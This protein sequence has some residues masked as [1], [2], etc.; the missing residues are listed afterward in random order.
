MTA[1]LYISKT[2]VQPHWSMTRYEGEC[3]LFTLETDDG[4]S[5][6]VEWS[7]PEDVEKRVSEWMQVCP[8]VVIVQEG[9]E[10]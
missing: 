10:I 4:R 6:E 1:R 9:G 7:R 2:T 5:I 3:Y 8:D